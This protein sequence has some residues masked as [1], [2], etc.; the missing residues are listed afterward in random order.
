V[1]SENATK[2]P[3]ITVYVSIGNSDDKLGQWGWS[4]FV[5]DF[6]R[7]MRKAAKQIYGIWYSSPLSEYQNAC[8]AAEIPEPNVD[9]LRGALTEMCHYFDQDSIAWAVVPETEFI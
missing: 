2:M 9:M 3:T 7:A 1:T 5:R 8:I 4:K 6:E